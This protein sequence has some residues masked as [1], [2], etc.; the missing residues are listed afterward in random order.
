MSAVDERSLSADDT[1][2][3]ND[4][5]TFAVS[6]GPTP[7]TDPGE[8]DTW[9]IIR[10]HCP[11][12]DRPIALLGDEERLPQHAVLPTAWHPFSPALCPG[13]GVPA[14]DLAEIDAP[15]DTV[16]PGLEGLLALPAALDWRTQPFSHAVA[17]SPVKAAGAQPVA[18]AAPDAVPAQRTASRPV[19]GRPVQAGRRPAAQLARR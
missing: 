13:S 19:A 10:V 4:R 6:Y 5:D 8:A 15:E 12:C 16:A 17:H 9:E 3:T 14:D 2:D 7:G 1:H 11:E 18:S